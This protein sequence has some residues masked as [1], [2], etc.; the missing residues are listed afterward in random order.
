MKKKQ[1]LLSESQNEEVPKK[2]AR[3]QQQ[4]GKKFQKVTHDKTTLRPGCLCHG[5]AVMAA[6]ATGGDNADAAGRAA[7][8][9]TGGVSMATDGVAMA[10]AGASLLTAYSRTIFRR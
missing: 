9:E 5:L 7:G 2:H 8:P 4:K 6:G 3:G 10:T 1:K